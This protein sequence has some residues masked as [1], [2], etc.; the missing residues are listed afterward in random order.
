MP[1]RP[2]D[3]VSCIVMAVQNFRGEVLFAGVEGCDIDALVARSLEDAAYDASPL[4]LPANR[5]CHEAEIRVRIEHF[6]QPGQ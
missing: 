3:A 4:P 5:A 1:P 2:N 6:G